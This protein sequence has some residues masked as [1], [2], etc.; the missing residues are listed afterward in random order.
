MSDIPTILVP[1]EDGPVVFLLGKEYDEF[2]QIYDERR[3]LNPLDDLSAM[4]DDRKTTV[5]EYERV[6]YQRCVATK[7][8]D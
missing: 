7:E 3:D 5:G 6:C 2:A 4:E 8:R 1:T